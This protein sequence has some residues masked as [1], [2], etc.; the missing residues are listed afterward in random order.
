MAV[1]SARQRDIAVLESMD[2]IVG[3]NWLKGEYITDE[4]K[5]PDFYLQVVIAALQK[6]HSTGTIATPDGSMS[7]CSID[8]VLA[9]AQNFIQ[10]LA[11]G[12]GTHKMPGNVSNYLVAV[13]LIKKMNDVSELLYKLDMSDTVKVAKGAA[14]IVK[15]MGESVDA[16]IARG[17][18]STET[19]DMIK[20]WRRID[21]NV[22][23]E[24]E[25]QFLRENAP[26]P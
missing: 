7:P 25:K 15:I 8:G 2:E 5:Q 26:K 24:M 17:N 14:D 23:S 11:S 18:V 20:M 9:G 16:E 22:P 3:R 1:E 10:V 12:N 21:E 19:V 13:E 4:K 6:M